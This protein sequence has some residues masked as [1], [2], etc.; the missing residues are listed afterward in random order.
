METITDST[1][2]L[3]DDVRAIHEAAHAVAMHAQGFEVESV[4]IDSDPERGTVGGA[5]PTR[6]I[7]AELIA[8]ES[9]DEREEL[10]AASIAIAF[11]G[12]HA[13]RR[14]VGHDAG[15][16]GDFDHGFALVLPHLPDMP[17]RRDAN[18][19]GLARATRIVEERWTAIQRLAAAL[20]SERTLDVA[21]VVRVLGPTPPAWPHPWTWL[22]TG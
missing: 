5:C 14:Y 12:P 18:T 8:S 19:E 7:I 17:G 9:R 10:G 15:C 11:A 2:R 3:P 13:Q 6:D 21:G 22:A 4:T 16:D 1:D 20:R